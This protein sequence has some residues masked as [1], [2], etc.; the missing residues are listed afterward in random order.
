MNAK[1][2]A[3]LAFLTIFI[4]GI[5]AGYFLNNVIQRT[6]MQF[7]D[8]GADRGN[9][10]N[11][12]FWDGG[13]TRMQ[14]D[15]DRRR[16]WIENHFT[17]KLNLVEQQREA[18]FTRINEYNRGIRDKIGEQRANEREML[19]NYYAEFRQDISEILTEEQLEKLDTMVHPDSVQ[20]MRMERMRS[21]RGR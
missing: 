16:Q 9:V 5:I 10:E 3:I 20:H 7:S 4:L 12:R 1:T 19:R 21:G 11:R 18:F 17:G 8:R 13:Q 6:G 15:T 2:K 14:G